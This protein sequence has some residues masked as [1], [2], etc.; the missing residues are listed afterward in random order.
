MAA[1]IK[2]VTELDFDQIKDNLKAFLSTQDK[3]AD[4]DFDGSSINI[5]LDILA[6]N[7]QYNA[8][9]AHMN[10][11][12][13][14]LDSA[15]RRSNV[16]SHAKSLGYIP[17]SARAATAYLRVYIKSDSTGPAQITM[18]KGTVFTGLIGT[19]QYNFVTNQSYTVSKSAI[20]DYTFNVEAKQ[21]SIKTN[22]FRVDGNNI[23]QKFT[24]P[25]TM[26]D[27]STLLV[28]VRPSVAS[29]TYTTYTHY[30]NIVNLSSQ[31]KV[32]FVQEN[33]NGEYE[34]Y[35]GDGV[36]GFKPDAGSIVEVAYVSTAGS[37][38]N[39]AK[40]FSINSTVN[41]LTVTS[42]TNSTGFTRT[43]DGADKESIDSIRFNAPRSF[44]SQNRAVTATDY[45]TILKSE[46]DFIEDVNIWGGEINEPPVY[47]KVYISIKP[48]ASEYLSQVSKQ[49]IN[50]FLSTRN[51]GSITAEIVD[52]NYTFLSGDILFKYDPNSTTR[53]QSQ[54]EAAVR[55]AILDYN[56]TYLEKFD[57]VLRFSKLLEAIDDVDPGILNSY[58]R[59]TMHKH[60]MPIQGVTTDYKLQFCSGIYITDSNEV[61]M[62]S[63]EF[64]Y[65]GSPNAVF[66]DV[67]DMSDVPNRTVKIINNITK[68]VL[69]ENAGKIYVND[70]RIELT[71]IKFDSS[72]VVKIFAEPESNDI[73]PKFNQLVSIEFDDTP[74]ITVTGEVDLIATLGAVGAASYTTF[75]RHNS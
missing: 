28:R 34:I 50:N 59:L 56:D 55:T 37:E 24:I 64:T 8:M 19:T 17:S 58:A 2:N 10:A 29:T 9:L 18:P 33:A 31:S 25:D 43:Q 3:F 36:I 53:T 62:T 35:F 7:T 5:L 14:F 40:T 57:G 21:G 32:Y 38:G 45:A 61:V 73:A 69:L 67:S 4:Y 44:A 41:G 65:G 74:G 11:N 42:V 23:H 54:L 47:G 68:A 6:Y 75:S 15:Q 22:T 51:I 16:V 70:G 48:F 27:T 30:A 46:Y 12:E 63:S 72:A 20:F 49:T 66:T 13:A 1:N 52:P 39:G 71:Q 60:L 26:V